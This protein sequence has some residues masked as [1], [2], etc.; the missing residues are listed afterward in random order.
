MTLRIAVVQPIS[1][2]PGEDERNVADDAF[3]PRQR[4]EAAE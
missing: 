2:R 4:R 3:Y 1:H